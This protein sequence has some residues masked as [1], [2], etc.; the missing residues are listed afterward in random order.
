VRFLGFVGDA[1]LAALYRRA[2]IVVVPSKFE[3]VSLPIWEAF[4]AGRPVACSNVTSLPEQ[5]GDAA[6][7]FDPDDPLGIALAIKQLW[8]NG[9]LREQLAKRGRD[10]MNAFSWGSTARQYRALYRRAL[11]RNLDDED[12]RLLSAPSLI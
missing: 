10:R 9:E 3:S 2:D 8:E 5:V 11:G 1:E 4:A 12:S 7:V 6:M